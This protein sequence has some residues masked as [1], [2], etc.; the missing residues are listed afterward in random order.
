MALIRDRI[1]NSRREVEMIKNNQI[2][3]LKLKGKAEI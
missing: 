1:A 3:I 2:N